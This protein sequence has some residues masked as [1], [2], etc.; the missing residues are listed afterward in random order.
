[1][2]AGLFTND[3]MKEAVEIDDPFKLLEDQH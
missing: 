1:M 3:E 2:R